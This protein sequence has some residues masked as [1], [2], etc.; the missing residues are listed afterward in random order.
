MSTH[1]EQME[2][3]AAAVWTFRKASPPEIREEIRKAIGVDVPEEQED[4]LQTLNNEEIQKVLQELHILQED[5]ERYSDLC[6]ECFAC[7]G[8]CKPTCGQYEEAEEVVDR[9]HI[10]KTEEGV[11]SLLD[12]AITGWFEEYLGS[13]DPRVKTQTYREANVAT[14]NE[15]LV[16]K[17]DGLEF[18]I[19][20][21]RSK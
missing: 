5:V 21:V 17:L 18:Q 12:E 1:R 8:E 9:V 10:P 20:V 7:P 19:T 11:V 6:P 15:G 2:D 3:L 14:N 16:L 4:A 13:S